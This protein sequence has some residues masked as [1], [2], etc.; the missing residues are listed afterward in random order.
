MV[1]LTEG[2]R[3]RAARALPWTSLALGIAAC[4]MLEG[5]APEDDGRPRFPH[6]V[7]AEEG[8]D[9]TDCHTGA[10]DSDE[11]GYP[12]RAACQL[13]H[14]DLDEEKPEERRADAFFADGKLV[15]ARYS[16]LPGETVFSHAAHA[17]AVDDCEAC[18]TGIAASD[19][20]RREVAVTMD[21]CMACHEQ[22]SAPNDCA[23]CH[24]EVG[25]EWAP[26][27]HR[28]EWKLLHGQAVRRGIAD[29][30]ADR[31]TLCHTESSCDACHRDEPP[32]SHTS[33]FRLKGHGAAAAMDRQNCAACHRSDSCERCHSEVLPQSHKG[34]WG[35][36]VQTHCLSCHLPLQGEGCMVCHRS[37]P[38]HATAAPQPPDHTPGMNCRQCHGVTQPLPHVDNGDNCNLCHH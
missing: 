16:A 24:T 13:C 31:C 35:T 6:A 17:A 26:D 2:S 37:T 30:V 1:L 19:R 5:G 36:G 34:S 23:T 27:S 14:A 4:A 20:V 8:L 28:H 12:A 9:C 32:Q 7:H 21:E 22:R 33:F 38:G 11:P 25:P 15:A 29:A 10:E 3:R 18:H